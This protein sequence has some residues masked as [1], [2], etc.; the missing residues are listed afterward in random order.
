MDIGS[1]ANYSARKCIHA[2][3]VDSL[4]LT[5]NKRIVSESPKVSEVNEVDETLFGEVMVK[6]QLYL[7]QLSLLVIILE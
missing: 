3:V 5:Q 7:R 4:T 6:R 1:Q 2:Y